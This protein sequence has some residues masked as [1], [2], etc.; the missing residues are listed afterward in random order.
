MADFQTG[1]YSITKDGVTW[2]M[3]FGAGG[4]VTV[5]T[6]DNEP[7][8]YATYTVTGDQIMFRDERGPGACLGDGLEVGTYTWNLD[9]TQLTFTKVADNCDGRA[10]ALTGQ[11][12]VT[13]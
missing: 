8:V 6:A 9:G 1:A 3:V 12:W 5:T 10:Q 2:S 4:D 7:D 13:A 11:P